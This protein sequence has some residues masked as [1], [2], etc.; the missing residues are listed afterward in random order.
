MATGRISAMQITKIAETSNFVVVSYG[1]GWAY[2]F[3]N[4]PDS[5]DIWF[6]DDDATTFRAEW[7]TLET[8]LPH[9]DQDYI[10]GEM[11]ATYESVSR[12]IGGDAS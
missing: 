5:L 8:K 4:K 2:A 7:N 11:W 1:N 3:T 9:R 6:Q 12:P 10:L